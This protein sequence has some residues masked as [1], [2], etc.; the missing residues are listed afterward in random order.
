MR[1]LGR[2]VVISKKRPHR[3]RRP[4]AAGGPR[5]AARARADDRAAVA[6]RF[7]QHVSRDEAVVIEEALRRVRDEN[8]G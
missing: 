5:R 2:A 1:D 7:P 4:H 8:A 3:S 6:D